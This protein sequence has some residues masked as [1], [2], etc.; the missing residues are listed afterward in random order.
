MRRRQSEP[1]MTS[2]DFDPN[3]NRESY[4]KAFEEFQERRYGPKV[5]SSDDA[6]VYESTD[7]Y[8]S[9][10]RES[11]IRSKP[12]I[13]SPSSDE[14]PE[15]NDQDADKSYYNITDDNRRMRRSLPVKVSRALAAKAGRKKSVNTKNIFNNSSSV[16]IEDEIKQFESLHCNNNISRVDSVHSPPP[17]FFKNSSHPYVSPPPPLPPPNATHGKQNVL[18]GSGSS[19]PDDKS[20]SGSYINYDLSSS[21]CSERTF[22]I[23]ESDGKKLQTPLKLRYEHQINKFGEIVEYAVAEGVSYSDRDSQAECFENL[24][25]DDRR[26]DESLTP[27][28]PPPPGSP[29]HTF[30]VEEN[31]DQQNSFHSEQPAALGQS[32]RIT[33]LDESLYGDLDGSMTQQKTDLNKNMVC[34]ELSSLVNWSDCLK[35]QNTSFEIAEKVS[36]EEV[37]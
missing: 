5:E 21:V 14:F 3:S 7:I 34:K 26:F 6:K 23:P 28:P 17:K 22:G 8:A 33:D 9:I 31:L 18:F 25:R 36:R 37:E 24:V 1:P 10:A 2:I 4:L 15:H 35:N 12:D 11:L 16:I 29:F 19:G 13:E 20:S 32:V 30:L 27:P